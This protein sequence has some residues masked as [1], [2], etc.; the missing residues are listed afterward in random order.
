MSVCGVVFAA[1][2]GSRFGQPKALAKT[3]RGTPW[4]VRAVE[5]LVE[6][7][8]AQVL[9]TLGAGRSE[10]VALVPASATVVPVEDWAKG[11]AASVRAALRAAATTDADAVL[12]VPVDTPELPVAACQ[13]VL[14]SG[15]SLARATYAS[16]PGHPVLIGR[17]H[18]AAL[19]ASIH[20]DRGAGQYLA[21]HGAT[22]IECGDLW[23]GRDVDTRPP[24]ASA[25]RPA[26]RQR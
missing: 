22:S 2:A 6:A 20:G 26:Q 3:A 10:A 8:C 18:W 1:G 5:T 14:G 15:G 19:A 11:L 24:S 12:L 21:E 23:H 7:G 16:E 13:R 4:V 9:V 25:E 17:E